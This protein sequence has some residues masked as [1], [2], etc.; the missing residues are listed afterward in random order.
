MFAYK[1]FR[2]LFVSTAV[3][4]VVSDDPR[5]ARTRWFEEA[6]YGI[7][8]NFFGQGPDWSSSVDAFDV[9]TFA[10][11]MNE[12]KAG[13]VLFALGQNNGYYNSP[14]SVYNYY[15]GYESGDRCSFR[16][17]PMDVAHALSRY[18][19]PLLLYLPSRAP[20]WDPH[21]MQALSDTHELLPAPQEFTRKW[22]EV[23]EEWSLRYG[24]SI[25]GWWF[26]GAYNTLGWDF[27][28]QPYNWNTWAAACRAG[29]PNNI[30]AFNGLLLPFWTW[31]TEQDYTAGE[32]TEFE[33]TPETHPPPQGV[34]W[35]MLSHLGSGFFAT[36]G[37]FRSDEEMIAYI[38]EVN[39]VGG[40]VTMEVAYDYTENG[41]YEPHLQ[42]IVAIGNADL[43]RV[44]TQPAGKDPWYS[45]PFGFL[46][47]VASQIFAIIGILI[48]ILF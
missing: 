26:D 44:E 35:H 3:C 23:I 13:Y 27:P 28:F 46:G 22:S 29:N 17:L 21:A 18:D 1:A 5:V 8:L 20:Q 40:V 14:N 2:L 4:N 48:N 12:A 43:R 10:S 9:D 24:T 31:T 6:R 32:Q 45:T 19:I 41:I 47:G 38:Q 16:D 34:Q 15:T 37:P 39:A 42:L 25:R 30:L 11:Q 33:K 36:D 7:M